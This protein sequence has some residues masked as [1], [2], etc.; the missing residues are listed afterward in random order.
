[1]EYFQEI[2]NFKLFKISPENNALQ[3][4]KFEKGK[5]GFSITLNMSVLNLKNY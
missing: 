4:G 5:I 1:M 3:F 2:L